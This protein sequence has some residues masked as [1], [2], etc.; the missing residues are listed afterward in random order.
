MLSCLQKAF[1]NREV[2]G[3]DQTQ[4]TTLWYVIVSEYFLKNGFTTIH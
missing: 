2:N 3:T 4:N 1:L